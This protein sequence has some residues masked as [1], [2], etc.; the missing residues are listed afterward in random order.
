[1]LVEVKKMTKCEICGKEIKPFGALETTC[2]NV[3]GELKGF[4]NRCFAARE[5]T[6]IERD[7]AWYG[8]EL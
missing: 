4:H 6:R 2:Y 5:R 8:D 3:D 1:M 7:K